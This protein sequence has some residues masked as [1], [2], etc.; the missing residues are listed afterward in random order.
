MHEFILFSPKGYFCKG[1]SNVFNT[2]SFRSGAKKTNGE[3]QHPT[4]KLV[5]LFEKFILDSTNPGDVV[6]DCFIG[7]GT[8]A[9]AA[10]K[11][12]RNYIGFEIQ[13]K[14]CKIA[15]HRINQFNGDFL[16]KIDNF[17]NEQTLFSE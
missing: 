15:Q 13:E 7:S 11:T 9:I 6:L 5:E 2:K 16:N 17:N 14:Y 10:I 4:Q 8:L 12:K 1:A 3:K